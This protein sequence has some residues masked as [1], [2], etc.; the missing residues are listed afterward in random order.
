MAGTCTTVALTRNAPAATSTTASVQVEGRFAGNSPPGDLVHKSD[1][2]G[3][4]VVTE[5]EVT[6]GSSTAASQTWFKTVTGLTADEDYLFR[7]V[8]FFEFNWGIVN[9]NTLAARTAAMVAAVEVPAVSAVTDSS[10]TIAVTY[11][12]RVLRSTSSA[13]VQVKKFTDVAWTNIGTPLTTGGYS[14]LSISRDATGLEAST[15]YEARL[16]ITRGTYNDQTLVSSTAGFT[17]LAAAPPDPPPPDPEPEPEPDPDPDPGPDPEP[18]PVPG[19]WN[20]VQVDLGGPAREGHFFITDPLIADYTTKVLVMQ[21]TGPYFGKGTLA[22]EATIDRVTCLTSVVPGEATVYW[23]ALDRQRIKGY[24]R[25]TY[26][27]V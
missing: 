20:T 17:T 1:Q 9:G 19:E 6:A 10:A 22:D 8:A 11:T 5:H 4:S 26:L 16:V 13:Q 15:Q 24:M 14:P 3:V 23:T 2:Y 18:A 12:P 21:A 25:F 7:A 27:V